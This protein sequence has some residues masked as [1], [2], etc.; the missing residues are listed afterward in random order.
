MI[1]FKNKVLFPLL[2]SSLFVACASPDK[3]KTKEPPQ[4]IS[5]CLHVEPPSL[6]PRMGVDVVSEAVLRMLFTGLT[7]SDKNNQTTLALADHYE[8]SPDRKKYTFYLK[9]AFWSDGS[10]LTAYDFEETWKTLLKPSFPAPNVNLFYL[11]KN[12]EAVKKGELPIEKVGI[13]AA[14]ETTLEI[15]LENPHATFLDVLTNSTFYPIPKGMR[16]TPLDMNHYVGCGPFKLKN[17]V[18]Q[19]EITLEKNP[20]YFAANETKLDELRFYIIK[21]ERTSQLLFDKQEIDWLSSTLAGMPL[22]MQ[23]D[24]IKKSQLLRFPAA[25]TSWIIFNFNKPPLNNVN[26]RKALTLAV[27]RQ[28]IIENILN[29]TA[30]AARSLIPRVQKKE[31]WH[32]YFPDASQEEARVLFKKGLEEEGLTLKT[33]PSIKL[34]YN[35][36]E[37]WKRTM[38]VLQATWAEAFGIHVELECVDFATLLQ[39]LSRMDF[40]ISRFGW[41][42]QYDDPANFLEIFRF[43]AHTYNQSGWK[44]EKFEELLT[45]ASQAGSDKERWDYLEEAEQIFFEYMPLCPLFHMDTST[46]QQSYVKDIVISPLSTSD[47]RWAYIKKPERKI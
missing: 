30:V 43:G 40:D 16:E 25:S 26:I 28:S 32:P 19:N 33:F 35:Q 47:F 23:G 29:G 14:D 22:D 36:T 11:I 46:T 18:L 20:L 39:K 21:D 27:N 45:K 17:Y 9:K 38:Q 5:T 4:K 6:D 2:L 1:N 41:R 24:L 44:N 34:A 12:A 10:P 31:R 3:N 8:L 42:V 13:R 37:V 7:F 15:E